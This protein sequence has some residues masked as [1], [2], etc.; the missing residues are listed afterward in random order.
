MSLFAF[1]SASRSDSKTHAHIGQ[2]PTYIDP[3]QPPTRKRPWKSINDVPFWQSVTMILPEELY[4]I[5][6]SRIDQESKTI[7]YAKVIMKLQDILD[8]DFFTEYVKKGTQWHPSLH[9]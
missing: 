6:W 2:L 1:D 8:Q 9:A 5:I 3:K 7:N 4:N